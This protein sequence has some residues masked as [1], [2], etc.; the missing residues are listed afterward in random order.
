MRSAQP[1]T[2]NQTGSQASANVHAST[3]RIRDTRPP[4]VIR[5]RVLIQ[6]NEAGSAA[7]QWGA[8]RPTG[9]HA[10]R[11]PRATSGP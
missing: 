10:T 8:R 1:P 6:L 4:R 11:P 3:Q 2:R 5:G 7:A 9:V